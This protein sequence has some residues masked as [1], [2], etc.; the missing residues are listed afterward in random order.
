MI[1]SRKNMKAIV[2]AKV[3]HERGI[4]W[5]GVILISED[6]IVSYGKRAEISIPEKAEIIDAEGA[7]V[8][9]GFV[10]IHVHG[11]GGHQTSLEPALSL[12]WS[13]CNMYCSLSEIRNL[14]SEIF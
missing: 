10:D 7:Y 12:M 1:F 14:P 6:K 4:I 8:G 5:D 11:G 3:V 9:P 2:N 13:R